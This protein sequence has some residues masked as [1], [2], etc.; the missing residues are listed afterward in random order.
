MTEEEGRG[1]VT[2]IHTAAIQGKGLDC[3]TAENLYFCFELDISCHRS[4]SEGQHVFQQSIGF[5]YGRKLAP[6]LDRYSE[7]QRIFQGEGN[8]RLRSSRHA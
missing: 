6:D 4:Y 8:E 1:V 2:G 5:R 7:G 3:T